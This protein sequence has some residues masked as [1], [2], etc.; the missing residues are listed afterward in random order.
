MHEIAKPSAVAFSIFILPAACFPEV[1]DWRQLSV[2]RATS[3]PAFVQVIY[4][5]L[6]L[7]LPLV[8]RINVANEVVSNVV[9]DLETYEMGMEHGMG[10]RRTCSSKRWPNFESS[11]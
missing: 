1:G 4:R 2:K 6:C 3:I 9:T 7:C 10:S 11:Q 5:A 8:S